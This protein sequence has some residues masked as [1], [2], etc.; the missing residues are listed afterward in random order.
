M[1][2]KNKRG[3]STLEYA[4]LIA[5]V[6]AGLLMLQIYMKR[7]FGGRVKSAVDDLGEQYDPVAFSSSY[8]TTTSSARQETFQ[9]KVTRSELTAPDSTTRTG[10][11]TVAA[12]ATAEDLWK[13]H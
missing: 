10:S 9:N 6:V 5:V 3:Q 7:G 13:D 11:E 4:L 8:N 12:W 1:Y 2:L